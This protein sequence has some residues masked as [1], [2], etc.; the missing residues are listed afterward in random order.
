MFLCMH[1]IMQK[2][3]SSACILPSVSYELVVWDMIAN[4]NTKTTG[5]AFMK[6]D[7][8]CPK[9]VTKVVI[10]ITVEVKVE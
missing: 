7:K 4:N 5:L 3:L 1:I 2:Y 9:Q 10:N 6:T 8:S